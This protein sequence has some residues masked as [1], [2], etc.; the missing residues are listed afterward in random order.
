MNT[1][2]EL[3]ESLGY[4]FKK[5]GHYYISNAVY[6]DGKDI[7][8]LVYYPNNKYFIDF[9]TKEKGN[10]KRL[11]AL[12]L[13]IPDSEVD[14]YLKKNG[15]ELSSIEKEI[16]KPKIKMIKKYKPEILDELLNDHTFWLNK[17][18][19]LETLKLFRGGVAMKGKLAGRY[20]LPIFNEKA[21][22]IDGFI[23]RDLFNN[24]E[25]R[26]KYKH[27]GDCKNFIWPLFLNLNDIKKE[28]FVILVESSHCVLKLWDAGIKNVLCLFGLDIHLPLLNKLIQ[29]DLNHI[30][31]ALNNEP[32]NKDIGKKAAEKNLNKLKKFF[33]EE[34]LKLIFPYKKDFGEQ[35]KEENQQWFLDLKRKLNDRNEEMFI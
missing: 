15:K 13:K 12:T 3:L 5:Q 26:P 30:I 11:L 20:V 19:S 34:Q 6:R 23:G 4:K 33:D 35:T 16:E 32:D 27:I 18:I 9:V 17:N 2:L 25:D 21:T 22:E 1:D 10:I 8:S 28:K 24:I 31:L 14:K 29:L 7:N